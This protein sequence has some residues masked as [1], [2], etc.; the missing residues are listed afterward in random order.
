MSEKT[1]GTVALTQHTKVI[2][3]AIQDSKTALE[4]QIATLVGEVGLLQ[5]DHKKL[6]DRVK[7]TEEIMHETTP[8]VKALM[9]KLT[10]MDNEVTTLAI[11]VDDTESRSR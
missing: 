3:A 9:Q 7:E 5:D 8:Q 4:S 11:K 6:K 10:L 1:G 2:L